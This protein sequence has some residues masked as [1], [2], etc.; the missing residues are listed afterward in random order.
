MS[1][2]EFADQ[3]AKQTDALES[4]VAAFCQHP[5]ANGFLALRH[6]VREAGRSE[7]VARV[8]AAWAPRETDPILAAGAWSE[9]GEAMIVTGKTDDAI[10]YLRNALELDPTNDRAADRLLEI[11]EPDDPALAVEIL[12]NELTELA[13]RDA[14]TAPELT[15]RR[16]AHHWRAAML[17]NDHLGRIDRALW[18]YQQAWRL[19]PHN[20]EPLEAA[21][22]LYRSLGDDAMVSTL[23]KAELQVIGD[24]AP[25]SRKA[26]IH[27]ELGRVAA[28]SREPDLETAADQFEQAARFDPQSLEIAEALAEVYSMPGFR[29]GTDQARWR[30]KAGAL[31]IELGRSRLARQD[32]QIGI[33]Y[34]RRAVGVDPFAPASSEALAEA[35]ATTSQWDELDRMLRHRSA[36]AQDPDE[37]REILRRR[38]AL[39]RNQLPNRGGLREVLQEL[40][41]YEA[42][43]SKGVLELKDLLREDEDWPELAHLMEAEIAA[44]GQDPQAPTEYTVHEILELATIAREHLADRDRAAELLHQ[45]LS[46]APMHE[47]ALARYVD[48]FRER[49]DWRGLIDLH[50]FALD[51]VRE[52]G[53]PANE[54]VRRLEEIAQLAELRLGDIPRAIDAWHRIAELEPQSPK[55]SEALRRLTARGKMWEQLVTSLQAEITA[56]T[57]PVSRLQSLKKM[58]QTYRE[59]QLEP[60]RTIELYEQVLAESPRDPATIKALTELYEKE[61]DDAGLARTLRHQLDLESALAPNELPVAKRSERLTILRRLGAIYETRL[62][63]VDGV[64][65]ACGGILALLPGDRDALERMERVLAKANDPRLE[66]ILEAHAASSANPAERAK[67]LKRL[68]A[69]AAARGDDAR[70]LER[71]EQ[72]LRASPSDKDALAALAALYEATQRWSELAHVLERIDGGRP[73]PA[74][75]TSEAA[76]RAVEL[77]RYALVLDKRLEDPEKAIAAWNRVLELTPKNRTALDALARLYRSQSKWRELADVLGRQIA[78]YLGS[79]LQEDVDKSAS[80]AMDRAV[81]FEQRLGTPGE[82]IKVLDALI[83]TIHPNHLDAHSALRRLHEARGDFDAAVRVAEREMFLSPD[84]ARKVTRGLEIGIICRDRLGNPTRAL[85]AFLRVLE[86]DPAQEQ[87]ITAAADLLAKLGRWRDHVAMLDRLYQIARGAE[88]VTADERLALVQRIAAATADKLGDPRSAFQWLRQAHAED[89]KDRTLADLRRAGETYGLWAELAEVLADERRR[90]KVP[91]GDAVGNPQ[92]FV[93]LSRELAAL[94]ERRLGDK[95]QALATLGEAIL[96]APRDAGLLSEL[97]RLADEIDGIGPSQ[98]QSEP[99]GDKPAW[100]QVLDAFDV[101]LPAAAPTDR[102]DLYLRRARI[103]DEKAADPKRALGDVLAAFSWAPDRP[104]IRKALEA[105]APRANAWDELAAVDSALIDRAAT[106]PARIALLR[107]KAQLVEENIHDLPRA[108]RLHLVALWLAPDDAETPTHLWRLAKAIGTY[109]DADK[110]P[111]P[112]PPAATIQTEA[113]IAMAMAG[114]SRDDALRPP[115]TRSE[116]APFME[117]Q[118][119]TPELIVGDTTQPLDL[120]GTE[121]GETRLRRTDDNAAAAAAND[122]G[123]NGRTDGSATVRS[124]MDTAENRTMT[125]S[126]NDLAAMAVPSPPPLRSNRPGNGKLPAPPPRPPQISAQSPRARKLSSPP[127]MPA[128]AIAATAARKPQAPVRRP[129]LPTLPN[130]PYES[131]W[132]EL[133]MVYDSLPAPEPG[134][135]M[136]WLFRASEVWETGAND[137]PRAFD[138]LSRAFTAARRGAQSDAEVRAR[139]H[140]IASEHNAW[141]RLA[142]LYET[143]AESAETAPAAADLLTEVAAIRNQQKRPRDAEVQL[144]RILGMLPNDIAARARLEELYRAEGRWVELAASLEE[145]TDPRLGTAAPEAERPQLLRE[146][147]AIYTDKIHRP[148]DAI[149]AFE[150]LRVLEPADTTVLM[151]LAELFGVVGRWSKVTETLAKV[152]EVAEGSDEARTAQGQIAQIYELELELPE[153]AIEAYTRLVATWPD[154]EKAWA[155][156]DRLYEAHGRWNE[157]AEA[158]R[159]RAGLSRSSSERAQLLSRR[160]TILLDQLELADEAAA[161]LR[162]ARTAAPDEPQLADQLV[163]ALTRAGRAREASAILEDRI[164]ALRSQLSPARPESIT[165]TAEPA[166]KS[167]KGRRRKTMPPPTELVPPAAPGR[168]KGDL[169]ALFIRLAQLRNDA[170]N[171][172]DGARKAIDEAIGL[173]PEH[174]TA[175]AVLAQLSSPDEDPRAFADAKLREAESSTDEDVKIAALMAAGE[176]LQ[177][178]VGD[179]AAAQSAYER[180]LQLR[181]YHADATWALAGLSEKDGDADAA[182]RLLETKL[183]DRSLAPVERARV[184]TQLAALSRAAGVIPAS[185][186]RLLEA[187]NAAPDHA[188]AMVALADSYADAG[189]W[190]DL[191]TFLREILEGDTLATAPPALIADLHRRL[192]TAHEQLGREDDAYQTLV[193]ADRLQRGHLLIKLAIGE[194]RYK[195]R[196]WREAALHLAPLAT[197]EEASRYP[198]E[199]AQGLYHAALAEIRSLRAD[200]APALYERALELKPSFAPALQALAEIAME[201]GDHQRAADLLSRQAAATEE[202]SERLRLF[203][204]IGDLAL[205]I[206]RDEARAASCF[207]A[208]VAAAKP[209]ETKH[210]PLLEK[211]LERQ[212]QAVDRAG[213]AR[214]AELMASFGATAAQRAALHLRAAHD[215]LAAGDRVRARAAGERAVDSDPYDVGAVELTSQLAIEQSDVEAAA[216][217]LTRLLTAKDDRVAAVDPAQ[218]AMMAYRLGHARSVRGDTRQ[219]IPA[220]EQAIGLA[221]G[222]EAATLARRA[223]VDLAA[224]ESTS[225]AEASSADERVSVVGH[226]AAI[227]AATGELADLVAWADELRR[228]RQVDAAHATLE[229]AVAC[230]HQPDSD[231]SAFLRDHQPH[232]LRDDESYKA[233]I[234]DPT[235]LSGGERPA[236]A[237]IAVALAEAAQ[238]VWPNLDEAFERVGCAGARRVPASLNAAAVAMFPRL[239]SVLGL[240]A[241]QL[242]Q[243][244]ATPDV[245]V[246]SASTP[247]IVLGPRMASQANAIPAREVRALLGRAIELSRPESLAFAGLPSHDISRLLTSV[248]RLFGPAALRDAVS[249]GLADEDVQ[250]VHDDM[251]KSALPVKLRSR[252][253]QLLATLAPAALDAARYLAAC[254]RDADRAALLIGGDPVVIATAARARGESC[255]HLIRAIGQPAWLGTR[256][257]IGIGM[258]EAN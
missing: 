35:L 173:V 49:R 160:A 141:D 221:P 62:A 175:L 155:A 257:R 211:L 208:A 11:V 53:A 227:T 242:Y 77:E 255:A 109:R 212:T 144:R 10:Q 182:M 210:L 154:D 113:A 119:A 23:L 169:A 140:R 102:V 224:R 94:M 179:L 146:L 27:L 229:L 240:S 170:M 21:R 95:R 9:A 231:Q 122:P 157:L 219:A 251:V 172:R 97:E 106:T 115:R 189:R 70:A 16:A 85:Q 138:T 145:R 191:E 194:N 215:Y 73:L 171:D 104:D 205:T 201:Q 39:Y 137:I 256:K 44:L 29:N 228:Q 136:R 150:R 237:P 86:L 64:V 176:V 45:A 165:A 238:H 126:V 129:P 174:P 51:N 250:R 52:A 61:G 33:N 66:Q 81:L 187:L 239:T 18:H 214:T 12:E 72:T 243:H 180:V 75:A 209:L 55:V 103:I 161:T 135:R 78:V 54:L 25:A 99:S 34:L 83:R 190:S 186:R 177:S 91:H 247:V 233:A 121:L 26:Q 249:A 236:L 92:P 59:R 206:L 204:A 50:E 152:S 124:R 28:S 4:K 168:S 15:Q 14:N 202:P 218:R 127:P 220:L 80:I 87:A 98:V 6:E 57:D 120:T 181:P 163:V 185:E 128:L 48:H 105:L 159:R 225:T 24:D 164:A 8:C 252:L 143:L 76:L 147:A 183:E 69:L 125:L 40:V 123:G 47:E 79:G 65:Y 7:L 158:L 235:L 46:I 142:E 37:R 93:A 108:F 203:E 89:P 166:T 3:P 13:K 230:G 88:H 188:P 30:N 101:V 248:A 198:A 114:S 1:Q 151:K 139:L 234:D 31:Y 134:M 223:L 117:T 216:A 111:R 5:D 116:T 241:V 42:P 162:L 43:G 226:L 22:E 131:P 246:V 222:S 153:R 100:N 132:E 56:A 68:A 196:R 167:G 245:T 232:E 200:K 193:A 90:H 156:L 195:A 184:L 110:S 32:E 118:L 17:W 112:E 2:N 133:A 207:A 60:Q 96:A 192:A 254:H 253:E 84:P 74:A 67:L 20:T 199:V 107:D 41:A 71:W 258:R 244:D 82:A 197:H 63:D 130:R 148:H 38:A 213:A 19:D 58:A 36:V 217:M 149:D 178:R